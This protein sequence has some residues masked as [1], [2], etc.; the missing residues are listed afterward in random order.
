MQYKHLKISVLLA[1][2]LVSFGLRAQVSMNAAG[3][4]AA[5][6]GGSVSYSVG[7]MVFSANAGANGSVTQGVQQPY[8]ISVLSVSENA[9]NIN[10]SV[11]PNPS[12]DYLCLTTSDEISDLSYQLFDM[13]GRLLKSG[14]V[15]ANQT[16]IDMQD[17]VPAT[18]FVK[19]NQGNKTV[20]S[21]KI[22][23]K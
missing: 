12:T 10:L 21:F 11:Y 2:L 6:D 22:I 3:G 13:S 1:M 18:Y 5:G 23:K 7:Q 14:K 20:K 9:E 15:V 19:V 4:N 8:E 17:L 16:S